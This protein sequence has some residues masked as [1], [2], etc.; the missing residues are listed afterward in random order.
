MNFL[1][2]HIKEK[3]SE[4]NVLTKYFDSQID[5]RKKHQNNKNLDPA[6]GLK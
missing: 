1:V 5:R 4:D 3:I 2:N 6:H